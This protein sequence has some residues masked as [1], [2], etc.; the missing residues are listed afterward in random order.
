MDIKN[1][2]SAIA[3]IAEEKGISVEKIMETIEMAIAAAYKKDYGKKGQ[4]IKAK[5]NPETGEVK[6]WQIKEV[7]TRAMI[8]SDEELEKMKDKKEGEP[9][10]TA[11]GKEKEPC[12]TRLLLI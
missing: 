5:L 9:F 4:M 7:V 1:F 2:T 10:D 8:Y 12:W 6:F 3:Q 11:Q